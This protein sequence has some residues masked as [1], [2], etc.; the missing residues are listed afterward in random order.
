MDEETRFWADSEEDQ[1]CI[2]A[3]QNLENSIEWQLLNDGEDNIFAN[4]EH[5]SGSSRS[6]Q[7]NDEPRW[8]DAVKRSIETTYQNSPLAIRYLNEYFY[9]FE[10]WPTYIVE[11]FV[12]NNI[13]MYTYSTRNKICL[14][15]WGNGATI[16]IM[17]TLSEFFAPP[18]KC[19]T[20]E[21][22]RQYQESSRKCEGLFTTYRN[23]RLNPAYYERYY[24]YNITERR[25]LYIDGRPRH[26]GHRQEDA[27]MDAVPEWTRIRTNRLQNRRN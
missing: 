6:I 12:L 19:S 14:F 1:I 3:V 18:I 24:Y 22:H 25:M 20:D 5:S 2:E 15:F 8:T 27:N 9:A 11:L 13:S 10:Q 4:I 21:E 26:Y 23:E 17:T 16:D 7:I